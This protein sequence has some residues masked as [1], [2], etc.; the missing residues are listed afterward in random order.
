MTVMSTAIPQNEVKLPRPG[1]KMRKCLNAVAEAYPHEITTSEIAN[2][3]ELKL[4]ITSALLTP[5]M[6]RGL[7]E[8]VKERCGVKGGSSWELTVKARELLKVT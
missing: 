3:A 8:R 7:V 6:Y 4:K 1:T 2:R 5:L